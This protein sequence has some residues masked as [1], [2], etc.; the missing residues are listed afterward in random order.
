MYKMKKNIHCGAR[1]LNHIFQPLFPDKKTKQVTMQKMLENF[2]CNQ[3]AVGLT[4]SLIKV[5]PRPKTLTVQEFKFVLHLSKYCVH[6]PFSKIF[7]LH[8]IY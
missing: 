1:V 7:R 5:G 2:K 6:L 8:S 4:A 3:S